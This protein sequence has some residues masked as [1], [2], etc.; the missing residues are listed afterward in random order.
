[1]IRRH[2]DRSDGTA[3]P[4][5]EIPIIPRAC[6]KDEPNS[7]NFLL[8]RGHPF[9]GGL[10]ALDLDA[11]VMGDPLRSCTAYERSIGE[12]LAVEPW[13]VA[14]LR[15]LRVVLHEEI[16]RLPHQSRTA[17][18][19]CDL[20][21][22]SSRSAAAQLGWSVRR[23][24][25]RLAQAHGRLQARMAERGITILTTRGVAGFLRG[26]R[27]V[28][29]GSLIESTVAVAAGVCRRG[30]QATLRRQCDVG[31]VR[32]DSG[33]EDQGC[34]SGCLPWDRPADRFRTTGTPSPDVG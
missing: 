26:A 14:G 19:L 31:P 13:D 4:R 17:L 34:S 22:H 2:P 32:L 25:K 33:T 8:V 18:V 1:M 27:S 10:I 5:L 15:E 30:E 24:E 16:L 28:V 29:S 11:R 9:D 21:G 23:I 12:A 20:E 3:R 6:A 7:C